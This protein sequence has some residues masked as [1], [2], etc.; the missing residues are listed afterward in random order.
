MRTNR[1]STILVLFFLVF[2]QSG[3]MFS[4]SASGQPGTVTLFSNGSASSTVSLTAQQMNTNFGLEVPRNVTFQNAEFVVEAK[5]EFTSPGQVSLDINQDGTKEW[6]FEGQGFGDMGIQTVFTNNNSN[7]TIPS[8]GIASSSSFYLPLNSTLVSASIN[9]S[10]TTAVPAGLLPSGALTGFELTDIDN[11]TF[12]EVVLFSLDQA[13]TGYQSAVSVVDYNSSSGLNISSWVPTCGTATS[14]SVGDFN[15]DNYSD[16]ISVAP[17]DNRICLH[18]YDVNSSRIG[19]ATPIPL[20]NNLLSAIIGDIDND[21]EDDVVSIHQNG[22]V[23]YRK[24]IS[25]SNFFL[26]NVTLTVNENGSSTPAQF[27]ALA[28]DYFN[29]STGNYSVIVVDSLGYTSHVKWENGALVLEGLAFDGMGSKV[30]KGDIDNDGDI[31]FFSPTAT[32]YTIAENNGTTWNTVSSISNL[33]LTDATL[34]DHDN[35]G[36]LSIVLPEI[37]S[38]DGNPL[39]KNGN[40]TLYNISLSSLHATTTSFEPWTCPLNSLFADMD[41]DGLMEHIVPA[42][43]GS[44]VGLF[45]G[46]HASIEMD[47]DLDGQSDLFAAG[48]AGDGQNGVEPLTF[49]DSLG[50]VQSLLS[51]L[52]IGSNFISMDYG[53]SMNVMHFNFTNT[54]NGSFH[55]SDLNIGYDVDFVVDTNPSAS[56]NLANVLNQLQTAGTGN[57]LIDLPFLSTQNGT[58]KLSNLNADYL[59]GAPNL[60]LPPEPVLS[61]DILTHEKV[62]ILWQDVVDFGDD[63]LEFQ[64][65]RVDTGDVFDLNNPT[66][67]IPFNDIEDTDVVSGETY[68]YSVRSIHLFGVTSNM[69]SRLTVTIPYPAPPA[70]VTGLT[71]ADT[72]SDDGSSLTIGWNA[73]IDSPQEYKVFIESSEILSLDNLSEVATVSA[74]TGN[75]TADFASDGNSEFLQPGTPYWVSVVA[76]DEYGNT[77]AQFSSFGPVYTVN[78]TVRNSSLS[79]SIETS[80]I[81]DATSFEMSALDSL[82]LNVS[83]MSDSTP[84]ASQNLSLS[85][86]GQNLNYNVDGVTDSNGT[87]YAIGVEDLTELSAAFS[88]F[89]GEITI[90]ITYTGTPTST[91]TQPTLA[92]SLNVTGMGLLRTEVS[93]TTS[94][95]ELNEAGSFTVEVMLTPEL[96]TQNIL[97]ANVVY[98][99]QLLN[100]SGNVSNSG[101]V[102]VKGGKISLTG[103]ANAHDTLTL[104]PLGS[105]DWYSPSISDIVF[106]FAATHVNETENQTSNNSQNQTDNTTVLPPFPDATLPGTLECSTAQYLWEGNGTDTAITCTLTNPNPFE[107]QVDFSWKVVPT[108]PPPISFEPSLLPSNGPV[109]TMPANGTLEFEF[110]PVRNGPSDGLFPGMQG[111]GYVLQLTC[112]DDET[113]RCANMTTPSASSE[114]EIQW[115]LGEMLVVVDAEDDELSNDESKGGSGALVGGIIA[116]LVLGGAGA[117][118]VLLRPRQEDD[119]WFDEFD[120]D[121]E[122]E[123]VPMPAPRSSRSLDEIKSSGDDFVAGEPPAERRRSLFDEV[124]GK[125]RID[126]ES[127]FDS[128][129]ADEEFEESEEESE[130]DTDDGISVDEDGTEWWEDEE[131]VW[132]YR[133][134]G[135][136]DWA[137]WEE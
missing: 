12:E 37:S 48:Y 96:P 78:N 83:L 81:S 9:A 6:A 3:A 87:W 43:E 73:S 106:T 85:I 111:V 52:T 113:S 62:G 30:L 67:T 23:S 95:L 77:S 97:L 44:S 108:T 33:V 119:D 25:K 4:A 109:L 76:Y 112:F 88:D 128:Q 125:G 19:N 126:N 79:L 29:G 26:D 129:S 114:G 137:V 68:D 134:E 55:L 36:N 57:I 60:A 32:G 101:T 11:D 136:E 59:P 72:P 56:G 92:S 99:W 133:E 42:G 132:W 14:I 121:D 130:E 116:L 102:E 20:Y 98:D 115:T 31:D 40:L 47:V 18:L 50:L 90:E 7:Q 16:V 110:T 58:M 41:S 51:P 84:L 63:F 100:Q 127:E 71:V 1:T 5:E 65:F 28:G 117:A 124:D 8:T 49:M 38:C 61:L 135:W 39:T 89:I 24:Y 13:T 93:Q 123:A 17:A 80:G 70:A 22:I 122:E 75:Y 35:D 15:G 86:V 2:A 91:T 54:G 66:M 105:Q 21:G 107:V 74:F 69:S 120:D 45:I 64:I 103:Q 27:S 131:G 53:I 34:A 82:H 104:S 118:F 10:F 94:T 46:S